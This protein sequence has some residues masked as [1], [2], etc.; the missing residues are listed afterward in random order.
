MSFHLHPEAR[1]II[2]AFLAN[3][4]KSFEKMGEL[5]ELRTTYEKN[6]ALAAIKGLEHIQA[7]DI[8]AEES[9][10]PVSL[11]IYDTQYS[12]D[13]LRPTVLFIHGG[14]WVI[15]NLNTHD[16]LKIVSVLCNTSLTNLKACVLTLTAW[17]L[18]GTVQVQTWRHIWD[19][20]SIKVMPQ[21]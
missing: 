3:G 19:K 14:G 17:F 10:H 2:E 16:H 5:A 11:R 18:W 20:A 13:I 8:Q 9:G 12:T 21:S 6:C 15:G 4:G 7:Q 1:P